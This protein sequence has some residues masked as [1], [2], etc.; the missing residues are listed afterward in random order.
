VVSTTAQPCRC[1]RCNGSGRVGG[2]GRD[3]H[4]WS[5][6]EELPFLATLEKMLGMQKP[7]ACPGCGGSGRNGVAAPPLG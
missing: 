3:E 1:S 4:P 7:R 6:F 2:N 5:S